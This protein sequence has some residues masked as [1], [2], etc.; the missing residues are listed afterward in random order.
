MHLGL[1][2]RGSCPPG[3]L[4]RDVMPGKTPLPHCV[5]AHGLLIFLAGEGEGGGSRSRAAREG[6]R[7][8]LQGGL[9]QP[10]TDSSDSVA[11]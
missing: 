6:D 3:A 10:S 4:C 2:V 1:A 5:P 7:A 8:Q 11:D 9:L